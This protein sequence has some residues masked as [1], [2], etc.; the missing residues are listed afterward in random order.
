[1]LNRWQMMGLT[2]CILFV[3]AA[4]F[5]A[6]KM[7]ER[8]VQELQELKESLPKPVEVT[9][10]GEV[11]DKWVTQVENE[12]ESTSYMM[13]G[14]MMIPLTSSYT[15]TKI[16]YMIELDTKS[17]ISVPPAAWQKIETGMNISI[18]IAGDRIKNIKRI[19]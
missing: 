1:M 16:H 19:K 12:E 17:K 5:I 4:A 13:S 15:T 9:V 18:T 10:E 11:T 7:G 8:F 2:V 14:N 6:P 3:G